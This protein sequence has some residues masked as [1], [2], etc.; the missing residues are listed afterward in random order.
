VLMRVE[1]NKRLQATSSKHAR[2]K[3]DCIRARTRVP[4]SYPHGSLLPAPPIAEGVVTDEE[5]ARF[6][7]KSLGGA[8]RAQ[9]RRGV[10]NAERVE[11]RFGG[12]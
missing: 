4:E 8:A 6:Q 7:T 2:L 12:R 10:S 11:A 9:E 1:A 3:V 5:R